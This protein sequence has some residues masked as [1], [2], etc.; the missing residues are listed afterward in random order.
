MCNVASLIILGVCIVIA[1]LLFFLHSRSSSERYQIVD[2]HFGILQS[3][4]VG[5]WGG[6]TVSG[7]TR[8]NFQINGQ[9]CANGCWAGDGSMRITPA[10]EFSYPPTP[11]C[12]NQ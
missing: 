5:G 3:R 6:G 2:D 11:L 12:P 1:A 9:K 7:S 8:G 10:C 4:G